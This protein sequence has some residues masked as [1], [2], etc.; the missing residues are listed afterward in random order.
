MPLRLKLVPV[1]SPSFF[2]VNVIFGSFSSEISSPAKLFVNFRLPLSW[3]YVF[4][5]LISSVLPFST[6]PSAA[7]DALPFTS[8]VLVTLYPA[9]SAFSSV[10]VYL[11]GVRSSS[12]CTYSLPDCFMPLRLKLVPVVSPSFFTV[13]LIFLRFSSEILSPAKL[14]VNFRLPVSGT[15]VLGFL[16]LTSKVCAPETT[17]TVM[18]VLFASISFFTSFAFVAASV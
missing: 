11:P 10:T 16:L 8:Y 2:T 6:V 15:G 17:S 5:I 12:C 13:N 4:V 3:L 18:P 14:F 1:V 9:T 7:V